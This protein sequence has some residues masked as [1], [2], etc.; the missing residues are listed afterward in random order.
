MSPDP[1][2]SGDVAYESLRLVIQGED[3]FDRR[4]LAHTS[5]VDLVHA[6]GANGRCPAWRTCWCPTLTL[7]WALGPR[8][9]ARWF[10][11]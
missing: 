3:L 8:P 9:R 5:S 2:I 1:G 6:I 7:I 11:Q 4:S 10:G